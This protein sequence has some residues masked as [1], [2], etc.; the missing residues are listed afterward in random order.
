MPFFQGAEIAVVERSE[1]DL[2]ENSEIKESD[3][4][5]NDAENQKEEAIVQVDAP[6]DEQL[7][8]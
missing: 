7:Q 8:H 3:I 6:S 4:S 1:D 2:L 5:E